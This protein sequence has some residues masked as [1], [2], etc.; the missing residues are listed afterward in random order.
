MGAAWAT[1]HIFSHQVNG[2]Q[3]WPIPFPVVASSPDSP[4]GRQA[5]QPFCSEATGT[6]YFP[7]RVTAEARRPS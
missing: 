3:G 5:P 4:G 2:G 6:F 1:Q 7:S